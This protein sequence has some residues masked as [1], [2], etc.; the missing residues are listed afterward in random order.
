[1]VGR[2]IKRVFWITELALDQEVHRTSQLEIMRYLAQRGNDAYLFG[3]RSRESFQWMDSS[4]HICCLPMRRVPL[5]QAFLLGIAHFIFLPMYLLLKRPH[6]II[7]GPGL[8]VLALICKP[9]LSLCTKSKVILDIR[10]TPV[11]EGISGFLRALLFDISVLIAKRMF[12]GMTALTVPMRETISARYNIDPRWIGVITSGVSTS[13]FEPSRFSSAGLQLRRQN[14]LVNKFVVIYHGAASPHRGIVES[15]ESMEIVRRNHDDVVLFLLVNGPA[16]PAIRELVKE[17]SLQ[18]NVVVHDVVDYVDV[19][20]YISMCDVGLVPLPNIPDWKYQCPL[21][22][23]EYLAMEKPVIVT[24]IPG[25]RAIVGES[26][27]AIYLSSASPQEIAAGIARARNENVMLKHCGTL[28][29]A[30]VKD[31]YDWGNVARSMEDYLQKCGRPSVA[32]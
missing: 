2:E 11:G 9:M 13:L 31:K 26:K 29:R 22:L 25:N 14:D 17:K 19:P 8:S 7:V 10:S 6:Y 20:K 24:D 32:R 4:V 30:I 16:V 18:D 27:C 23:L 28:G 12:D 5:I 15:V 1:M 21:N 3:T